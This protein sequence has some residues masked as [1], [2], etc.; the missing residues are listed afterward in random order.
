MLLQKLK[1]KSKN[2]TKGKTTWKQFH[3]NITE[4]KRQTDAVFLDVFRKH[5]EQFCYIKP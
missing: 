4:R 2:M 1:P 3:E 5:L